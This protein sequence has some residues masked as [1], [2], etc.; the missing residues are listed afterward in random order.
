[1]FDKILLFSSLFFF[2]EQVRKVEAPALIAA[3]RSAMEQTESLL[4]DG[5]MTYS[6]EIHFMPSVQREKM[7]G[8]IAWD[9]GFR[10][11]EIKCHHEHDGRVT[12]E[13]VKVVKIKEGALSIVSMHLKDEDRTIT[14]ASHWAEGSRAKI[15][16][17]YLRELP[18]LWFDESLKNSGKHVDYFQDRAVSPNGRVTYDRTIELRGDEIECRIAF[19]TA[20]KI[21]MLF[22]LNAGGN[23][24]LRECEEPANRYYPNGE[25]SRI[26]YEWEKDESGRWYP[27]RTIKEVGSGLRDGRLASVAMRHSI[28]V[29]AMSKRKMEIPRTVKLTT[30]GE[31]PEGTMVSETRTGGARESYVFRANNGEGIEETLK[32]QASDLQKKG[33]GAKAD[34]TKK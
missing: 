13:D 27:K 15:Y 16:D 32:R 30:L 21:R 26:T 18:A 14:L 10:Y 29:T 19:G 20:T 25:H 7:S 4:S 24:I 28:T 2:N 6:E 23:L 9:T 1:M 8:R 5:E 11:A 34:P 31:I 3:C 12:D 17:L 22:A 33:L